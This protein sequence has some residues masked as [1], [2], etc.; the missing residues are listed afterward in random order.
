MTKLKST[1]ET[2]PACPE[3]RCAV[4]KRTFKR[5]SA[6][7]DERF[8]DVECVLRNISE[9]GARLK[10]ETPS[11]VPGEFTLTVGLDGIRVN[12]QVVWRSSQEIGVAFTSPIEQFQ[13]PMKQQL[14]PSE[15]AYVPIEERDLLTGDRGAKPHIDIVEEEEEVEEKLYEF[16]RGIVVPS[17][18]GRRSKIILDSD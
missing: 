9:T 13:R 2:G 5:A 8:S 12:C 16:G 18:F 7:F 11:A 15:T 10:F 3:N 6:K 1:T 4:R 17:S 14:K